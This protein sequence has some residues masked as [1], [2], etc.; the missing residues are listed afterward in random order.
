MTLDP[1]TAS[2]R[3]EAYLDHLLVPLTR[4]LSGFHRDEL[5]RELRAHLWGRIDAYQELDYSEEDAVTEALKQFGGADGFVRQWQQ[6]WVTSGRRSEWQEILAATWPALR[7]CVSLMTVVWLMAWL[8]AYVEVN[9]PASSNTYGLTVVYEDYL[10]AAC[11][12]GF[13]GLS[14]WSGFL[15]GRRTLRRGGI[16]MF[17]ALSLLV[18]GGSG[19]FEISAA[20]GLDHT[21]LGGLFASL[22]LIAAAWMPTAC[23]A[24]AVSGWLTQRRKRVLA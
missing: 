21:I 24:A 17:A 13:F 6:E 10:V 23:L 3:I 19:L 4:N 1:A 8:L 9:A 5:R 15:H 12:T 14:L 7:L 20:T 16:G 11:G 22:P 2:A 18:A